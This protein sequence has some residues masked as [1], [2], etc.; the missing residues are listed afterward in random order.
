M[1]V[2][3]SGEIVTD[4]EEEYKDMPPLT[5]EC[6]EEVEAEI[7]VPIQE[8]VGLGLVARRA[9][10]THIKEENVQRENIFYTRCLV[11]GK[12]CSMVIDPGSCTNVASS[13]IVEALGLPTREHTKP[14]RL[15]WLN[16]CGDIKVTQQVL[17]SF[18]VGNYE[19]DVL[20][21]VVPMQAS[22]ILLGRPWQFD[23]NTSHSGRTNMYTF[24]HRGK[25][26][27]L[28]P[29]TPKQVHEDQVK[30]QKECEKHEVSRK[31]KQI[32]RKNRV[33]SAQ[34]EGKRQWKWRILR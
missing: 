20:C 4:D 22:H 10:A 26:V 25:K 18:K 30:I 27:T 15:Q 32:E 31:E 5:E 11:N 24:M 9:L 6:E 3:P 34:N 19:D 23:L 29:L 17:I 2:L 16:N 21:D 12:V 7:Q 33:K 8:S 13:I 28:A 14:Y 1:I